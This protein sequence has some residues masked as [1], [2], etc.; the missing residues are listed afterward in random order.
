VFD[1]GKVPIGKPVLNSVAYILDDKFQPVDSTGKLGQLF[2][3]SPNVAIG[4]CGG[5]IEARGFIEADK[6][7][8]TFDQQFLKDKPP[9]PGVNS[10]L[11]KTGDYARIYNDKL[12][13]YGRSDSQI[14]VRGHRMDL[15]EIE[16]TVLDIPVFD[17]YGL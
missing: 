3:S 9:F 10:F 7:V 5:N 6:L 12:Y 1:K 13:Y 17:S 16:K 11:Y 8:K 4:Y 2:I 14:K 15:S